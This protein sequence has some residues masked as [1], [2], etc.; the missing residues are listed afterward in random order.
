MGRHNYYF[1][2][3]GLPDLT[4]DQGKLQFGSPEFRE[5]LKSQL[6][7]SDY[8]L[9]EWLFLPHDNLNL[10]QILKKTE[11]NFNNS[12]I[13]TYEEL[14]LAIAEVATPDKILS[15]EVSIVKPYI[16]KFLVSYFKEEEPM[17]RN[18]LKLSYYHS[19]SKKRSKPTMNSS[20]NGWNLRLTS[21]MY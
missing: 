17:P 18:L 6:H 10:L 1:L 13:Y 11:V 2:I 3:A 4:I 8:Q 16:K 5:Y 21:R 7:K 19:I 14:E 9:I 15:E 12:G 20:A